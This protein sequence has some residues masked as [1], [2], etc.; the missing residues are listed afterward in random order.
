MLGQ[1]LRRRVLSFVR[2]LTSHRGCRQEHRA[3]DIFDF[4]MKDTLCSAGC[5]SVAEKACV[6]GPRRVL[7]QWGA[8]T[9]QDSR[10]LPPA[11]CGHRKSDSMSC[12]VSLQVSKMS[13]AGA[14]EVRTITIR[15]SVRGPRGG[16]LLEVAMLSEPSSFSAGGEGVWASLEVNRATRTLPLAQPQP[17]TLLRSGWS[18]C[19]GL[20]CTHT[21]TAKCG[22]T[23]TTRPAPQLTQHTQAPPQHPSPPFTTPGTPTTP[24]ASPSTTNPHQPH[25]PPPA[26]NDTTAM[27]CNV[28]GATTANDLGWTVNA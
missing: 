17:Q 4:L 15:T 27:R 21:C 16:K 18:P 2:S 26:R 25:H 6:G 11:A 8:W 9:S 1:G 19:R 10:P 28:N 12:A 14:S 23:Q 5:A 3:Y 24:S 20:E 22:P 13:F 7:A